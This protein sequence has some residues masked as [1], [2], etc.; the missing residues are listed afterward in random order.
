MRVSTWFIVGL[1]C[2]FLFA[3]FVLGVSLYRLQT[4]KAGEFAEVETTQTTRRIGVPAQRG[5]ILDRSGRVLADCRPSRCIVCNLEELQ[6][7]GSWSNTVNAVDAAVDALA[8]ALELPRTLTREQ[9]VRH[10]A[11][12]S[13]LPLTV[14]R[15]LD[16]R[17]FARFAE[18]ADGFPGFEMVVRA[19]SPWRRRAS[20]RPGGGC[21]GG[22]LL[23]GA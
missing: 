13:A 4:V 5:R 14:W 21:D 17:T 7:R 1:G 12:A 9:V 18:R 20:G 3:F 6:Q 15:D 23:R 11:R 2:L 22:A 10:V 8:S 16:E 19:R